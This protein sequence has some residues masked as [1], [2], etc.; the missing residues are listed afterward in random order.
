MNPSETP[1]SPINSAKSRLT[2]EQKKRNHI[3]SEKKRREAIRNGFDR[4]STIVPGMHGQARSEAIVLAATVD[5]MRAMTKQKD[6]IYAAAMEKGWTPEQFNRYYQVAEQEARAMENMPLHVNSAGIPVPNQSQAQAAGHVQAEGQQHANFGGSALAD[7]PAPQLTP[8]TPATP[9]T[10]GPP[11][12]SNGVTSSSANGEDRDEAVDDL[13]A[14]RFC[15]P[16]HNSTSIFIGKMGTPLAAEDIDN[17]GPNIHIHV[18][19]PHQEYGFRKYIR[20]GYKQ[21]SPPRLHRC[22]NSLE[23]PFV[24]FK[25]S[26]RT[27]DV[28]PQHKQS[29]YYKQIK[30]CC[31]A[32]VEA[33]TQTFAL[34]PEALAELER[35][36]NEE[37]SDLAWLDRARAAAHY[38]ELRDE[39]LR[40]Q[41]PDATSWP[42][43]LGRDSEAKKQ[44][45]VEML[46]Q[47]AIG[48]SDM[49]DS[50]QIRPQGSNDRPAT[51]GKRVAGRGTHVRFVLP[52]TMTQ[53]KD[54]VS[55]PSNGV[56]IPT[57][58]QSGTTKA[59][60]TTELSPVIEE[61]PEDTEVSE[62]PLVSGSCPVPRRETEEWTYVDPK[63]GWTRVVELEGDWENPLESRWQNLE[64]FEAVGCHVATGQEQRFSWRHKDYTQLEPDEQLLRDSEDIERQR[65]DMQ[66]ELCL[67][68]VELEQMRVEN[69]KFETQIGPAPIPPVVISSPVR[70]TAAAPSIRPGRSTVP[71]P[72]VEDDDEEDL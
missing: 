31:R 11:A 55:K 33:F 72:T 35:L 70:Y 48:R 56:R 49:R 54:A 1:S 15:A 7:T 57:K 9:A 43:Q 66:R 8:V 23:A 59:S 65:R 10:P 37:V 25:P 39:I 69:A 3:E 28:K 50:E 26:L 58:L 38:V 32:E 52:P 29:L 68:Y 19:E 24:N 41:F 60:G 14:P 17:V 51:Y 44:N 34:Y 27:G 71:K 64:R 16:A 62:A 47:Q 45:V 6:Q 2:E 18:E 5:Y 21:C 67:Q 53:T 12:A 30:H 4:L 61:V 36:I 63:E 22:K 13:R 42:S 46:R 20:P 40:A